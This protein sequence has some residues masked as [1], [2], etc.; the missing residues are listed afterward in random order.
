MFIV[1]TVYFKNEV[2][3]IR[4]LEKNKNLT[5]SLKKGRWFLFN[6]LMDI[7]QERFHNFQTTAVLPLFLEIDFFVQK[8]HST[9]CTY[10]IKSKQYFKNRWC[11]KLCFWQEN[12]F[13]S[14]NEKSSLRKCAR[15]RLYF[16]R[17]SIFLVELSVGRYIP[18]VDFPGRC[19]SWGISNPKI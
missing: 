11:Q 1:F 19:W 3:F 5:S 6:F 2:E 9:P 13:W 10:T 16:Y 12:R 17:N 14:H 8:N 15:T 4:K 7:N 18:A